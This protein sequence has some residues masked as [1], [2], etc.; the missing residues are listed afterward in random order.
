MRTPPDLH[1][2][3]IAMLSW[4]QEE[5]VTEFLLCVALSM[6]PHGDP[7][8]DTTTFPLL[9]KWKARDK[10]QMSQKRGFKLQCI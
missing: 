2:A 6:I 1:I 3:L 5:M 9:T 4:G 7:L 8:A 10:Q